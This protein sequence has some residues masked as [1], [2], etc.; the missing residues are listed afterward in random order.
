MH[1]FRV[2]PAHWRRCLQALH[3]LGLAMV[4]TYV[5]WGVHER[6]PGRFDF[7][8]PRDLGAFLDLAAAAGLRAIVR[9]GPHINAELDWFGFPGRIVADP[10]FAM[11]TGRGTPAVLLVP[12]RGF[13]VPSYA[14]RAFLDEVRGWYAAVAEVVAPRLHPMGPVVALQ[15]DNEHALFFRSGAYDGDY[16]DEALERW[17]AAHGGKEPP[18]KFFAKSAADLAPHLAWLAFREQETVVALD[19]LSKMLDEVGLSAVPH[20]HN[21]PPMDPGVYDVAAA[22]TAVAIAGIDLYHP[23]SQYERVRRRAL[24][25]AG[26]S[27]LPYVPEMG[28]GSFPWG[29][30]LRNEDGIYQLLNALAHGVAGFNLY[31]AVERDRWLGAPIASDGTLRPQLAEPLRRIVDALTDAHWTELGCVRDVGVLLPRGYQRLA[32]ASSHLGPIGPAFGEWLGLHEHAAR[33]DSFGLAGPVQI[34]Q[35]EWWSAILGSLTRRHVAFAIVDASSSAKQLQRFRTLIVP[36]FDFLDRDLWHRLCDYSARGGRLISGPRRPQ[37]DDAFQPLEGDLPGERLPP[38]PTS[39]DAALLFDGDSPLQPLHDQTIYRRSDGSPALR[40]IGSRSAEATTAQIDVH[41]E[42][43][44][45][46]TEY[47]DAVPLPPFGVRL[48]RS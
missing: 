40:F 18:R 33:E 5:P 11:R 38:A 23:K 43:V 34:E 45:E 37:L 48:L 32:L 3:S 15:V 8:G 42:D 14:G 29:P 19:R 17:R 20:T 6:G 31:M 2:A 36:T 28:M 7:T 9:P 27:R 44:V 41:L 25:L 47:S 46:G 30:P 16:H 12:P 39:L 13:P 21:F 26:T 1:Y 35:S 24:Y 22:E 4:E 10:R